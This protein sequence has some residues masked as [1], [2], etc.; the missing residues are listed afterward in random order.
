MALELVEKRGRPVL[1]VTGDVDYYT[2]KDL[3]S[4]LSEVVEQQPHA[5]AVDLTACAYLDS[6]AV[7]LLLRAYRT[8][9]SRGET[10]CLVLSEQYLRQILEV[11][12]LEALP[13][14]YLCRDCGLLPGNWECK[15]G[16]SASEVPVEPEAVL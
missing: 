16:V 2:S 14:L 6:T 9:R 5:L 13:G 10:L 1:R 15:G 11:L 3:G 4:A 8:L 7:S 12:N